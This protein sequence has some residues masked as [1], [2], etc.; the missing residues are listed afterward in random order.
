MGDVPLLELRGIQKYFPGVWALRD[1]SFAVRRGSVHVVCG[2]NGAGKSTLVKII[3]G[4]Y[5]PDSGEVFLNGEKVVIH[6]PIQARRL[7]ISMVTQELNYIPEMTVEQSLFL[8]DEPQ[9]K[10]FGIDWKKIRAETIALLKRERLAYEPDTKLKELSVSDIQ[11][12]EILKAVSRESNVIVLD[13]PT[14]AI[15]TK[16]VDLLFKKIAELRAAGTGIIYISH[17][18]DELFRVADDITVIRDGSHVE[19]RPAADFDIETIIRLMVGR[20]IDNVFPP[21]LERSIGKP[22][23]EVEDFGNETKFSGISFDVRKGEIVGFSGLM[24]AG[25][26]E[27]ARSLFG[28]DPYTTGVIRVNGTEV[29][30]KSVQDSI[31]LGVAMLS[32]DRKRYGI[33]PMRSISENIALSSLEKIFKRGHLD[34]KAEDEIITSVSDRMRVKAP[35]LGTAVESLSGGNQQKVVFAKWMLRNPEILILDEPTR[36]IDVGAKYEIYKI[37]FELAQ[38]GK[39]IVM[40]SSELPE[41]IGVCDRI[42]VMANGTIS[43]ELQAEEFSQEKIMRLATV[44]G[45][46]E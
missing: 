8:G 39:A 32:E 36:G 22:I 6:N 37:I 30:I 26:T 1:M 10:A 38:E 5:Q 13:E 21:K 31:Q 3:S 42:Y 9:N 20:P 33:V 45:D 7:K 12:L 46:E 41:L 19:T 34:K 23:L 43:G 24:G 17:R 14:S 18:L 4:I 2:E 44:G 25:R 16:E 40:I 11:M 27:V 15:T 28:L 35:S 29:E